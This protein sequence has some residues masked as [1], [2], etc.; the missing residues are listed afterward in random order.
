MKTIKIAGVLMMAV[1]TM[2]TTRLWAQGNDK[3][4]LIVKQPG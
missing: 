4:Q 3:Q 2:L 1:A